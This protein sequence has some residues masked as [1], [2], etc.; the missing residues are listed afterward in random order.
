MKRLTVLVERDED[1]LAIVQ[2][3]MQGANKAVDFRLETVNDDPGKPS[4]KRRRPHLENTG[5]AK[6]WDEVKDYVTQF[7][8]KDIQPV[9]VKNGMAAVS[10]TT[11]I[12]R[13]YRDGLIT[14]TGYAGRTATYSVKSVKM[15]PDRPRQWPSDEY[16]DAS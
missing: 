7:T 1:A 9:C 4:R 5:Q 12:A 14:K 8:V 11:L 2:L 6:C 15:I 16:Q 13:W 3:L 10:A